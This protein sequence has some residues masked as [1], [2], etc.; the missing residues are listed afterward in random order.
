MICIWEGSLTNPLDAV[1]LVRLRDNII[2]WV[3]RDFKSGVRAQLRAG[4]KALKRENGKDPEPHSDGE[5]SSKPRRYRTLSEDSEEDILSTPGQPLAKPSGTDRSKRPPISPAAGQTVS[6][7][8]LTA[9]STARNARRITVKLPCTQAYNQ[10][11]PDV[12]R[13][14]NADL[15]DQNDSMS[16]SV[17]TTS[18]PESKKPQ[19]VQHADDSGQNT[20]SK[21]ST[22]VHPGEYN[23]RPPK[24]P[25]TWWKSSSK[26]IA[27][28]RDNSPSSKRGS[29]AKNVPL[30][31]SF[32]QPLPKSA[33][34]LNRPKPPQ[35]G[36]GFSKSN[37]MSYASGD[38][39]GW[40]P[41]PQGNMLLS[42]PF[43]SLSLAHHSRADSEPANSFP[44]SNSAPQPATDVEQGRRESSLPM[45]VAYPI[46]D[47]ETGKDDRR[48]PEQLLS[49]E[50]TNVFHKTPPLVK[51]DDF[52]FTLPVEARPKT[53]DPIKSNFTFSMPLPD[54]STTP[55]PG[56]VP[57]LLVPP[58]N[59]S[60]QRSRSESR[61]DEMK[62]N[63]LPG[64]KR[65]W[66][67]RSWENVF[68]FK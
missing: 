51:K 2:Y 67:E 32:G 60:K 11:K 41:T 5:L 19:L 31:V 4:Y 22:Q 8:N 46:D 63:R 47:E 42:V 15:E 68:T 48:E 44:T 59:Q 3:R 13:S 20:P 37:S 1:K 9:S 7:G 66:D 25:R 21:A 58:P 26:D 29:K 50:T 65:E 36:I 10:Q 14:L 52:T 27:E 57:R 35:M 33:N 24:L 28:V 34:H 45:P 12:D 30:G 56:L 18:F 62:S 40:H 55:E 23:F 38:N 64:F 39:L 61:A 49:L 54:G 6:T 17:N 16:G 43:S 53:P